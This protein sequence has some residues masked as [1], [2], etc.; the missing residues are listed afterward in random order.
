MPILLIIAV[1]CE[2]LP[3]ACRILLIELYTFSF[4]RNEIISLSDVYS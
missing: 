1:I 2:N 3:Q 4:I